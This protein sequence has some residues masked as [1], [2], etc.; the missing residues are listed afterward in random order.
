MSGGRRRKKV[1]LKCEMT[2]KKWE[3]R[4]R[5]K[6]EREIEREIEEEADK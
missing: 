5:E 6:R 1:K 2:T 3:R 4:G